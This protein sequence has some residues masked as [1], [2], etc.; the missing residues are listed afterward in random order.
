MAAKEK[1]WPDAVARIL[2]R[3]RPR[4]RSISGAPP[5][6]PA[7]RGFPLRTS[8]G[9]LTPTAS[10]TGMPVFPGPHDDH[11]PRSAKFAGSSATVVTL[12]TAPPTTARKASE[13]LP[14]ESG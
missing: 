5:P 11:R 1:A 7:R 14:G 9:R 2:T 4:R 13:T 6:P 3:L 8:P 12:A 10:P